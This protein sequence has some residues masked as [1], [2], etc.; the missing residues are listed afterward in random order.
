MKAKEK[1]LK[2]LLTVIIIFSIASAA[3]LS[4][5]R[6]LFEDGFFEDALKECKPIV[7]NNP[8][9]AEAIFLLGRIHYNLGNLKKANDLFSKALNI[10]NKSEWQKIAE[11]MRE[12]RTIRTEANR[13]ESEGKYTQAIEQY[14]QM[15]AINPKYAGAYFQM[16]RIFAFRMDK[17]VQGAKQVQKAIDLKPKEKEYQK[18]LNGIIGNLLSQGLK[19]LKRGRSGEAVKTFSKVR[20]I[21]STNING[22]YYTAL[23]Y[24][25]NSDY[26][27]AIKIAKKIFDLREEGS[28]VKKAYKIIGNSHRKMNNTE[29]AIAAYKNAIEIDREYETAWDKL[30]VLYNRIDR[31]EQARK[32]FKQVVKINPKNASAWTNLGAVYNQLEQY[33]KAIKPLNKSVELKPDNY[34]AWYRLAVAYNETEKNKK[35]IKAAQNSLK[36]RSGWAPALLE[37][38]KAELRSGK[39]SK[40][41][42]HFKQAAKSPK[43]ESKANF[44]LKKLN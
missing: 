40:A 18:L 41:K 1:F 26:D 16:G 43:Y 23:A 25:Y 27:N 10:N 20:E 17:P 12:L 15:V 44:Y 28:K 19:Y 21:D 37:L 39:R 29:K 13:Y 30:G 24:Y 2:I 4:N 5:A 32:A 42:I 33:D 7:E 31:N 35:A 9:N 14:K 8:K 22:V 34:I 11:K 38:G 6:G 3:D 36:Y